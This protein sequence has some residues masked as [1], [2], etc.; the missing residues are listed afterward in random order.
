MRNKGTGDWRKRSK[1]G[2]FISNTPEYELLLDDESV[3]KWTSKLRKKTGWKTTIPGFLRTLHRFCKY[4]GKMPAE[5]VTAATNIDGTERQEELVSANLQVTELVR[6]F[7]NKLLNSGKREAARHVRTS[8]L[9]FFK[10]NGIS[11]KLDVIPRIA[12]K[13]DII[14]TK[15]Q[16]H[17]MADYAGSL[18]NRAIILCMFQSGLGIVALRNLDYKHVKKDLER[19]RIPI[20][21][22]ITSSISGK[23]SQVPFYAFLQAEACESLRAYI[24]ERKRRIEKMKERMINVGKLAPKSP[25]FASEGKNV[26]FGERMAV[27]SVWRIIKNSARRAGLDEGRI[28]PN[29]LRKA[30]EAELNRSIKDEGTKRYLMG[31]PNRD[32]K[33]EIEE[34]ER[35]YLICNFSRQEEDGF[36]TIKNFVK[37]LGIKKLDMRINRLLEQNPQMTEIE[38]IRSIVL[39]EYVN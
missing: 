25:L 29:H 3:K 38:A 16:I 2:Y 22:R 18:R 12:K 27:S 14:L 20:R 36:S 26:P 8:L 23:A 24:S 39:K 13:D 32:A 34:V 31:N 6:K 28:Q 10:A 5:L 11:L 17:T 9:S 15:S 30:F 35:K 7:I 21:V 37:S 1:S 19:A 4:S 33:Y